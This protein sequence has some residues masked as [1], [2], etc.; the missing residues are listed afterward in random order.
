VVF[1]KCLCTSRNQ[2]G[3]FIRPTLL[4][5]QLQS[6]SPNHSV[7]ETADYSNLLESE[8]DSLA[9]L[10]HFGAKEQLQKHTIRTIITPVPETQTFLFDMHPNW[11]PKRQILSSFEC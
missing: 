9:R 2:R 5:A 10:L 7:G 1:R 4:S 11:K 6:F 3:P 8:T